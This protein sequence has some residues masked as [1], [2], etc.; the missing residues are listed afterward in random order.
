[1]KT[2]EWLKIEKEFVEWDKE[3]GFNFSQR[4]IMDWFEVKFSEQ[5]AKLSK[6]NEV[7]K[8]LINLIDPKKS[9]E[10]NPDKWDESIKYK[11]N[12]LRQ[13]IELIEKELVI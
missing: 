5:T 9:F 8:E 6:L 12:E 4:Q 2:K 10:N 1:M 7:R 11:I 13:K 3:G